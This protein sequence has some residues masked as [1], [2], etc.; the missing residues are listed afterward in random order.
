VPIVVTAPT[1][2]PPVVIV[3]GAQ[4]TPANS[5]SLIPGVSVSDDDAG[6]TGKLSMSLG[7][8][9]GSLTVQVPSSSDPTA[10]PTPYTGSV[11]TFTET[12]TSINTALAGLTYTPTQKYDGTDT[13][14]ITAV[15]QS[16]PTP[17]SDHKT[18]DITVSNVAPSITAPT[19]AT[20]LQ[21]VT[22]PLNG[23][24]VSDTDIDDTTMT[25]TL[26]ASIGTLNVPTSSSVTGNKTSNV[27]ISDKISNVNQLLSGL[28]YIPATGYI[29]LDRLHITADDLSTPTPGTSSQDVVLLIGTAATA[30]V[31]A[32]DPQTVNED[33]TLKINPPIH[34]SYADP[35]KELKITL[36]ATHGT[37]L[38]GWKGY[39]SSYIGEGTSKLEMTG[40]LSAINYG[41]D[42]V[43]YFP[44]QD[45]FGTDQLRITFDP[46]DGTAPVPTIINL[47][48]NSVNDPPALAMT[49]AYSAAS[50]SQAAIRGIAVSDPDVGTGVMSV[51]MKVLHG[52]L[53]TPVQP[54]SSPITF[55]DTLSNVNTQL[56]S[57]V[58]TS[59]PSYV[60]PD[61]L[62][63][64]VSDNG[65]TGAG[66][67]LTDTKTYTINVS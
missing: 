19:M 36:E 2:V 61:F 30:S 59:L 35:N 7:V 67:V 63:I 43:R 25:V 28:Q 38:A 41:L 53:S 14:N 4:T 12:L 42:G 52:K 10:E 5:T 34:V 65:N 51:D 6:A 62:T 54:S 8:G 47:N 27:I 13:L 29:G 3:P 1:A 24:S 37:V 60:G 26:S 17:G 23:V 32:P 49:S 45:Y 66:G 55:N 40:L 44:N 57:I 11:I 18:V 64:T 50:G 21:N 9:Q 46:Q 33:T 22:Q 31:T 20:L 56:G 39:L 48:I 15:D 16:L 58:Y